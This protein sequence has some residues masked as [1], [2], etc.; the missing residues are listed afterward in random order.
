MSLSDGKLLEAD[1]KALQDHVASLEKQYQEEKETHTKT[2]ERVQVLEASV[3]KLTQLSR[4]NDADANVQMERMQRLIQELGGRIEEVQ[5]QNQQIEKKIKVPQSASL[6]TAASSL[7]VVTLPESI[8]STSSVLPLQ[9]KKQALEL[10]LKWLSKDDS[11]EHTESIRLSREFLSKWPKEENYS[12]VVHL[13]L[14]QL[15]MADKLYQKAM[16]EFKKVMDDTPKSKHIDQ[17]IF[18][19]G[20]IFI[21]MGYQNDARVFFEELIRR[22]PQSNLVKS[23]QDKISMLDKK[24]KKTSSPRKKK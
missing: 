4:Q 20:E 3:D 6:P 8:H 9:D 1:V 17:A 19:I 23:A 5:F 7:P 13:A 21:V 22:Y 18:R 12:D 15:Y 16:I 10:V 2:V 11:K 14:G 24:D